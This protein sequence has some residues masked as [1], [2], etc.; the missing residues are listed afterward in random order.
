[1]YYAFLSGQLLCLLILSFQDMREKKISLWAIV[2]LWLFCLWELF[3]TETWHW[4]GTAIF[5]LGLLAFYAVFHKKFGFGDV[6]VL[7]GLGFTLHW[8]YVLFLLAIASIT[9]LLY[10]LV[11]GLRKNLTMRSMVVPFIPFVS[12]AFILL[13]AATLIGWEIRVPVLGP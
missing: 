11:L 2:A 13:K 8:Y 10:V 5:S 4:Q 3:V 6:L 9:A 7:I 1:M 12:L